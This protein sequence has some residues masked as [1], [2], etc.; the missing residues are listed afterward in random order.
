MTEKKPKLTRKQKI[1]VE[2]Y[3]ETGN[4]VRSALKAYNTTSE[5]VAASIASENLTKPD[6]M[7][8]FNNI[9]EKVASNLYHLA[10]NAESEQVQLGA[11]KDILDRAGF[12]PVDKQEIKGDINIPSITGMRIIREE[13]DTTQ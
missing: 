5:R 11:G 4:G 1:F 13:D 3:L 9:A 8:Y 12:K 7:A 6:I 10:L 2:E